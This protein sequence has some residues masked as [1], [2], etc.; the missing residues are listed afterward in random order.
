MELLGPF[1][2]ELDVRI[3]GVSEDPDVPRV[4]LFLCPLPLVVFG[5]QYGNLGW[6]VPSRVVVAGSRFGA[7]QPVD[8]LLPK[9]LYGLAPR[10]FALAPVAAALAQYFRV[11][12]YKLRTWTK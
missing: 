2:Q 7:S 11:G 12:A 4:A 5:S 3:L 10:A 8:R 6:P 1:S 9:L